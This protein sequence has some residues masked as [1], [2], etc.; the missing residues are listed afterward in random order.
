MKKLDTQKLIE[1]ASDKKAN[2]EPIKSVFEEYAKET[3]YS[4]GSIRNFY[5]KTLKNAVKT[6]SNLDKLQIPKRLIPAF[7]EEFS[8][9][10][11]KDLC[12][13]IIKGVT[14]GKSV[15]KTVYELARGNDKLAL[16][17][18]NKIRN[19]IKLKPSL[20]DDAVEKVRL[21]LGYAVNL[22][23]KMQKNKDYKNLELQINMMLDK[24]LRSI[25]EETKNLK[26]RA[27]KLEKENA[28]LKK[29]VKKTMLDKGF[30]DEVANA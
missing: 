1:R 20:I 27:E 19:V 30:I 13:Y 22:R 6:P 5:Y 8:L 28:T 10:E 25:R 15:R 2:N 23:E 29:V 21:E 17:Y 16:R 24:I 11:E 9:A 12:Y 18:Q 3:G 7:I 14:Q 4:M 26:A